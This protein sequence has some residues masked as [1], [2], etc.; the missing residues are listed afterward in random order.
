MNVVVKRPNYDL[1]AKDIPKGNKATSTTRSHHSIS[2]NV[3]YVDMFQES[4]S[5]D[6]AN[7]ATVQ[8]L[9]AAIKREP[10]H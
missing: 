5:D 1:R 4:S 2:Q 7:E 6:T 10:S 3:S 9:G 8:P